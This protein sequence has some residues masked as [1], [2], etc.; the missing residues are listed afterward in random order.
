MKIQRLLV[1]LFAAVCASAGDW[2]QWRGPDRTGAAE[3]ASLEKNKTF[4][5]EVVW[6]RELGS[7]YAQ[8]TVAGTTGVTMFSD[9][10]SDIL[11]AF[12]TATGK[13]K[14]RH[15]I[16][17][18]YKGHTGSDDGP[19][20]TPTIADDMVYALDPHGILVAVSLSSGAL[21][22]SHKLGEDIPARVPHYGFNTVPLVAGDR[23]ILM[24]GD[25]QGR[26]FTAFDRHS[27]AELWHGGDDTTTYQSPV[28]WQTAG[29]PRIL[30]VTDTQ[31]M[32]LDPENG[33][34][35]WQHSHQ[36]V[37]NE[38]FGI[39]VFF[40]ADKFV[41]LNLRGAVAYAV[42]AEPGQPALKELWRTNVFQNTY[43]VPVA[44]DGLLF[45]FR[46]QILTCVNPENGE[47]V[48]RS[49]PPGG[50]G[51][52][53]L[54]DHL[55]IIGSDG[56]LVAAPADG[57]GFREKA[58]IDLF[59]H[60]S[61]TSPSYADGHLYVRNLTEM[62][63]V[64]IVARETL[65]AAT[66]KGPELRGDFGSFV[67]SLA[68][69]ADKPAAIDRFM[70][71]QK[72]FPITQGNLVTYVFRGD[73]E[74]IAVA[75]GFEDEKPMTRIADTDLF[76]YSEE[77]PADSQWEYNFSVYGDPR[78]DPL[79]PLTMGDA[80]AQRNE[81]RMPDWPAPDY[82]AAP[83]GERGSLTK[84]TVDSKALGAPWTLDVYLPAGY[85]TSETAYPLVV[86]NDSNAL[87]IAKMDVSLDNLIGARVA[88]VIVVF[89]PRG[90]QEYTGNKR[91][92]YVSFLCDELLPQLAAS[93]RLAE[94][95]AMHTVMGVGTGCCRRRRIAWRRLRRWSPWRL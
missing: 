36:L 8:I 25:A 91:D 56:D 77:L 95:A 28:L 61:Y 4:G 84:L 33:A 68:E 54:G 58:H 72:Q 6:K 29:G 67:K 92:Q 65:Q 69:A 24:T 49:R 52:T 75:R 21:K 73:V 94:G 17:P 63:S 12:D 9:G 3:V 19:S 83:T 93:Y 26:A 11:T 88:P 86:V 78:P 71:A 39:P 32:A 16:G 10:T 14:W 85:A 5:F 7:G 22:W 76:F 51:L 66:G 87:N 64:R 37:D 38:S 30:G 45:G 18:M 80:P 43:A 35:L 27:G 79:N 81:L 55:V 15:V 53:L 1:S 44:H 2:P 62:A 40:E 89:V 23:L 42:T 13:E 60:G 82:L 31:M 57:E 47:I 59:E 70:A 74:D 46:G 90:R 48:W 20:G 41:T 34:V 50:Q